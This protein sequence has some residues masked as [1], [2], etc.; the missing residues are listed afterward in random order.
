MKKYNIIIVPSSDYERVAEEAGT[1]DKVNELEGIDKTMF[2]FDTHQE[3]EAF[4][5][6]YQ[7]AIGFLGSGFYVTK[8][9]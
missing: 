3:L 8:T 2:A 7:S 4:I 6:G 9:L 5:K 1:F